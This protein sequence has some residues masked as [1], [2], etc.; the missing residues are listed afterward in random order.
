MQEPDKDKPAKQPA[1]SQPA[2]VIQPQEAPQSPDT[3]RSLSE[4]F[5]Q[6]QTS[7]PAINPGDSKQ[8]GEQSS[9]ALLADLKEQ[10]RANQD[11]IKE[12]GEK[13]DTIAKMVAE[14]KDV[15]NQINTLGVLVRLS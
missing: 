10:N 7:Q 3:A 6:Q 1:T 8:S 2:P 12:L 5:P 11:A 9:D 15:I 13:I 14:M 4:L